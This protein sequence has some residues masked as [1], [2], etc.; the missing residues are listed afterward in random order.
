M[1][2]AFTRFVLVLLIGL[3]VTSCAVKRYRAAPLMPAETASSFAARNLSDSGLHAFVEKNSGQ[4]IPSW[5][6]KLWDLQT[7]S[8]AAL[9]FSPDMQAARARLAE[10]EAASSS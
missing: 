1:S 6:P 10:A 2:S 5:P 8:S 9:Y 7:L 4:P 3:A